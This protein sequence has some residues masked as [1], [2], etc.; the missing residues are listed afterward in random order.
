MRAVTN[1]SPLI[2]LSR[3]GRSDLFEQ[4]R[5]VLIP[6]KVL[7][8]IEAGR[9]RGHSEALDVRHLVRTR[10]ARVVRV[11]K[12]R[13]Q[14]NLGPGETAAI[15]LALRERVDEIVIDDR[16]AIAIAKFLGL[17]PIS[18]PFLLLRDRKKGQT[19][20][21]AFEAALRRLL[22][23]GYYLSPELVDRLIKEGRG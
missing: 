8:E 22:S 1:T 4:Y 23:E 6:E 21:R 19:G 14:W 3:I 15:A 17:R 9:M 10:N 12:V 16:A 18:I 7:E 2:Y 11:P 20:Q 5:E 13:R